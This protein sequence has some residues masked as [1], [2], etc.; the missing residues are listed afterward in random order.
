MGKDAY[1]KQAKEK[2]NHQKKQIVFYFISEHWP[3]SIKQ[4]FLWLLFKDVLIFM[5]KNIPEHYDYPS[6]IFSFYFLKMR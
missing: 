4:E 2:T 1:K 5:A 6:S 3:D